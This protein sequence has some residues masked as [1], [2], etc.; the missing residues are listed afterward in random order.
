EELSNIVALEEK[1]AELN[2][3]QAGSDPDP[4]LTSRVSTLE[5]RCVNL[6]KKHKLQDKTTQTVASRIFTLEL[7]DL[8]HKIDQ[9][10]NEVV[11]EVVHVA[12]QAPLYG[13]F[14][15]LTKADMKEILHQQMFESGS[16]KSLPKHVALYEA[17]EASIKRANKDEFLAEKDKLRK[18]SHDDQDPPQ[19]P[20]HDSDQSKKDDPSGS[21]KQKT[22]SQSE[23]PVKDILVPIDVHISDSEDTNIVH[24]LKFKPMPDWLKPI[25]EED[26]PATPE[27][28]WTVPP[29]N[30]PKTKNNWANALANSYQDPDEFKLLR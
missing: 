27:P 10:V 18:Q 16:Y 4:L 28:H 25:P 9:T 26:R 15:E 19:P 1:T 20:P 8:L 22:A 17:L 29:N 5:Q 30:L 23:Q 3:G 11:K 21:L 12:L 7:R 14:K 6:E 2:E 13:L 24:L